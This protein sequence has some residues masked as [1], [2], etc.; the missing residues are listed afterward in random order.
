MLWFCY[1]L[2]LVGALSA[3]EV[4][5]S[6][7][8]SQRVGSVVKAVVRNV[9]SRLGPESRIAV[10]RKVVLA[11]D[12]QG[13][14]AST[15]NGMSG[16]RADAVAVASDTVYR[17]SGRS[18]STCRIH[19]FSALVVLS[20][21]KMGADDATVLASVRRPNVREGVNIVRYIYQLRRTGD[22]WNVVSVVVESRS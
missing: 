10:E 7:S 6:Q 17:C 12:A 5:R 21:P 14:D 8:Q 3:P 11:G 1:A 2:A 13:I 16:L 19:G 20:V 22:V 9:A 18:P 4:A 15:F